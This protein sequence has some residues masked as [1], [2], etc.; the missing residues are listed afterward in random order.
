[1]TVHESLYLKAAANLENESFVS[2]VDLSRTKPLIS[3]D[4]YYSSPDWLIGPS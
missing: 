3:L 4:V 2:C 1:M